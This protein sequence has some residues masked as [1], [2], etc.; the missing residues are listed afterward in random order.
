MTLAHRLHEI[1]CNNDQMKVKAFEEAIAN[2]PEKKLLTECLKNA[3]RGESF[4]N[5][6]RNICPPES[7]NLEGFHLKDDGCCFKYCWD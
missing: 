5:F 3:Q 4:I 1:T 2:H 7:L 6:G